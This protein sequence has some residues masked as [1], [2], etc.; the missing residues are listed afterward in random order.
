MVVYTLQF[1]TT[2]AD[3]VATYRHLRL[4]LYVSTFD[5]PNEGVTQAPS[6][7]VTGCNGFALERVYGSLITETKH[8][9]MNVS[10]QRGE[11]SLQTMSNF[12]VKS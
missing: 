3:G 10:L 5:A 2:H 8:S 6:C 7:D 4:S 9:V 12:K 11:V 1:R